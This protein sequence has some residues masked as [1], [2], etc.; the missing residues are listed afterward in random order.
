[1]AS[2]HFA[3]QIISR[4]K[5]RSA[6]AAAAYRAGAR[7]RNETTGAVSDYCRRQGVAHAEIMTP[8]GADPRLCD[9]AFLWN[10][11]EAQEKRKDAQLCREINLALPAL[12][13]NDGERLDL[14]RG[15]VASQFVARGMVADVAIHRPVPEKGD[16]PRNHHAHIM[17]TLRQVDVDTGLFFRTKTREWNA[18]AMLNRWREA[19]AEQ[20]NAALARKGARERVDHRSLKARRAEAMKRGDAATARTLD[21]EPEL[22]V[23]PR[24]RAAAQ[25]GHRPQSR[26]RTANLPRTSRKASGARRQ[27]RVAYPAIDRGQSRFEANLA[28]IDRNL[29]RVDSRL[30]ALQIRHQRRRR[31]LAWLDEDA[32]S[33]AR[34]AERGAWIRH[35]QRER[36]FVAI[37]RFLASPLFAAKRRQRL[38]RAVALQDTLI[39]HLL[40]LKSTQLKRRRELARTLGNVQAFGRKQS[41]GRAWPG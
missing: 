11:V 14:V 39:G 18:D 32:A 24:A 20:Q 29:R 33:R 30:A 12:E 6:V 41:R 38:T 28:R 13:M 10:H 5:G 3:A 16:D 22:H 37:L 35:R 27:R 8:A 26:E 7:L 25:R 21:R 15:F 40:G 9:R 23:G 1:M 4:G 31:Q 36:D 2:Y 34:A 17:L 19:W